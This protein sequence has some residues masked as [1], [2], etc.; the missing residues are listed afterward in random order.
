MA[1]I[2]RIVG[3]SI[4]VLFLTSG[5]NPQ[6][7]LEAVV[8]HWK[9]LGLY[10]SDDRDKRTVKPAAFEI[11]KALE[12]TS[13]LDFTTGKNI[14]G[15]L[16]KGQ[17]YAVLAQTRFIVDSTD[18]NWKNFLV[19]KFDTDS[20][21]FWDGLIQ[22]SQ[23]EVL[24]NKSLMFWN[25]QYHYHDRSM[26]TVEGEDPKYSEVYV[27]EQV[28]G[29]VRKLDTKKLKGLSFAPKKGRNFDFIELVPTGKVEDVA[30]TF[31]F[32]I[33]SNEVHFGSII[34][35]YPKDVVS[36]DLE[37]VPTDIYSGAKF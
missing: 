29:M 4:I 14:V 15:K 22:I 13:V 16:E 27:F 21:Q 33:L 26:A 8:A 18:K 24:Q 35:D 23:D 30:G 2:C 6:S 9:T 11:R 37:K 34:W 19:V 10:T 28:T 1:V 25:C 7:K 5:S 31:K 32:M 36:V 3:L 12:P 17:Q 20:T